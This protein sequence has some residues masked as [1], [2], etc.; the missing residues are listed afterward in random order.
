VRSALAEASPSVTFAPV[1]RPLHRPQKIVLTGGPGAGKTTITAELAKRFP[2]QFALVPEAAT[3]VYLSLG[4]RWDKLTL[5]GRRDVQRAIY[6]HQIIQEDTLAAAKPNHTALLDRGTIDGAAYWPDGAEAYWDDL[7]TTLEN[8]LARYDIVILLE[9]AAALGIYD[10]D[11]SNTIRFEDAAGAVQS[12]KTLLRLWGAHP[13]LHHV[14]A[15]VALEDKIE[16]VVQ[17]LRDLNAL[18]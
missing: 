13:R 9:T 16:A 14:G 6:R 5:D 12:Q 1:T 15:Y 18:R 4:T 3:A 17:M 7:G 11:A 2:D 8:Q 10:G